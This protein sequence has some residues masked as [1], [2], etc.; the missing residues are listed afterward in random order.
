MTVNNDMIQLLEYDGI[1]GLVVAGTVKVTDVKKKKKEE[2]KEK[3]KM[4]KKLKRRRQKK[5]VKK[6]KK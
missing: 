1:N 3:R 4:K 2:K 5:K 6:K